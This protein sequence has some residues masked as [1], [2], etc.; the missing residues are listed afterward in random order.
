MTRRF[1]ALLLTGL[2]FSSLLLSG[3]APAAAGSAT[4]SQEFGPHYSAQEHQDRT[5]DALWAHLQDD[6]VY[7]EGGDIDWDAIHDRYSAEID[8]GLTADE[9]VALLE[10]LETELPGH[11][12]VYQSRAERIESDIGNFATYGGIGAFVGF[13]AEAD[14]HVV[15]LD[16][17]AGSPAE[18]AGILP[19]DSILTIDGQPISLE[20]G[21][22]A[23]E[24]I[25]GPA[26]SSVSLEVRSPGEGERVVKLTRAQVLSRAQL[27]YE[28]IPGTQYGYMLFPPIGYDGLIEEVLQGMQDLT[29]NRKL[30]GLILDL[31]ISSSSG[32]WPLEEL[33]TL[34]HNGVIGEFYSRTD[35]QLFRI[36]GRDILDSQSLP[37][38][39]L[40]GENTSGFAEILAAGLQKGRRATVI[41]APTPGDVE[42]LTAFYL[43][44]GSHV[45]IQSTS[46]RLLNGIDIGL[47]GIEPDVSVGAAWDEI[48]PGADPLIDAALA[49]L[50]EPEVDQ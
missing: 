38:V 21:L 15:I 22:R 41:G 8:R 34:F 2:V 36:Q 48:V 12:L 4:A 7:Y 5:F 24:R 46:F 14:P 26:G 44:D 25:R 13:S 45:Q 27:Q 3:C 20:E 9:F 47:E 40:V 11:S 50:A 6:Y 17:I 16:V 10:G 43:P 39:V 30:G 29:Q 32:V 18:K 1:F 37:L 42:T 28:I 31:R 19:H 23:V 49:A 35:N 33:L